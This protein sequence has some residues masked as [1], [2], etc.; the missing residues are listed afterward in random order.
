MRTD[1]LGRLC[2]HYA[3]FVSAQTAQGLFLLTHSRTCLA[4]GG[5]CFEP[6]GRDKPN[7]KTHHKGAFE[8]WLERTDS[9]HDK[10][11]QNLLSYH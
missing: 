10:E 11:N 4:K 7:I 1:W 6:N 3:A 8:Y 2:R 9:N 5:R